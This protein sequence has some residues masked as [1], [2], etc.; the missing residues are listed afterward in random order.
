M[1]AQVIRISKK[2]RR[3]E[4]QIALDGSKSISNRALIVRALAAEKFE[5][6]RLSTSKDTATLAAI[7]QKF[8]A[9]QN[10]KSETRH[11]KSF[12]CGHAGTTFRFLTAFFAAQ[13]GEQILTGSDRMKNRPVGP[14]VEALRQLGADIEFLEKEGFPP[15]RIG[16]P[17][18]DFGSKKAQKNAVEI[19]AN[20]S[21]QFISALLLIGPTLSDGLVI[22]LA[23][24]V[25]SRS[26]LEMTIEQMRVFGAQIFWEN[27]SI[28]VEPTGYG[29][30]PISIEADWSAASYWL[31]L[32]AMAEHNSLIINGLWQESWQGDSV[33]AAL[34]S[35]NF[36]LKIDFRDDEMRVEKSEKAATKFF[37]HDF[38]N[39]P[40]IAQTL[41]VTCAA[42]GATGIFSGLETLA[43][44][45][46]DRIAALKNELR[47]VGVSFSKLPP[48]FSKKHPE[49]TFFMV[50]GKASSGGQI[51]RFSTYDDHRMAMAFAPLAM[52]FPIEIESPEVVEK[53]YPNFWKDL[54]KVGFRLE[55]L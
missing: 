51:P 8:E 24:R 48:H 39:C 35:K 43:I 45:E 5:I 13:K 50:E 42:T 44:K 6:Y 36:G 49:K 15:L 29:M 9:E 55:W 33:S 12:D 52:L 37:E 31:S 27:D 10:P 17:A 4:G 40:D 2:D 38:L 46:T 14:L 30:L 3:L 22:R 32:A 53:S 23:G 16:P 34:F 26:Y 21:S 28:R 18:A 54:E 1:A 25:V 7:L 11:P 47:K 41:A 19:A 20:V